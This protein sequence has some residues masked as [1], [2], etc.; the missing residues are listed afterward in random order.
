[1]PGR[2]DG[3]INYPIQ[4]NGGN[5]ISVNDSGSTGLV[6]PSKS[7]LGVLILNLQV[8]N[9]QAPTTPG[10]PY[11]VTITMTAVPPNSVQST[12]TGMVTVN[13]VARAGHRV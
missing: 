11:S 12:V 2:L 9:N 8:M 6:A 1:M 4:L 3:C 5:L 10:G 13:G 7:Q